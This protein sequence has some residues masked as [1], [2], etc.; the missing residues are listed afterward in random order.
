[1]R[2]PP[3]VK[4]GDMNDD[5]DVDVS[6]VTTLISYILGIQVPVFNALNADVDD[7][8]MFTVNDVTTIIAIIL[9]ASN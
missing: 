4:L 1:M 9:G 8:T 3:V 7:D 6:D 2:S 5:G